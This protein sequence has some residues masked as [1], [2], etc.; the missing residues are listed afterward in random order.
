MHGENDVVPGSV[1]YVIQLQFTDAHGLWASR[2][3]LLA[4][5][6]H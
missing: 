2:P 3:V 5:F 6:G 4:T 1:L